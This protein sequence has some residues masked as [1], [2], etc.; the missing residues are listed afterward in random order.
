[1]LL[2]WVDKNIHIMNSKQILKQNMKKTE[3]SKN[4]IRQ[5]PTIYVIK[6]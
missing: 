2:A 5:K 1:M 3:I 4:P 6:M